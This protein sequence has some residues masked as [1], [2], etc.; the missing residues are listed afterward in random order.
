VKHSKL[1]VTKHKGEL[2]DQIM[3]TKREEVA[4]QMALVP[5]SQVKAFA[6]LAPPPLDFAAALTAKPGVALIAEVKRASPSRGLIARDWDPPLIAET[7][8]RAGAAAISCLTDKRYFQGDLTYLTAI[9]DHL[10]DLG[11]SVPVLRKDFLFHEYQIYESRMAGADAILLIVAALSD[12][13]LKRLFALAAD[14][15]MQS[16]VEVHN[17]AELARAARLPVRL[18]GVNNRDLKTFEVDIETTARLRPLMP[19]DVLLIAESGIRTTDDVAH[20]YEIGCNAM[21]VGETF[22]RLPQGERAAAVREF[23]RAGR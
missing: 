19:A 8:A 4:A 16:L 15:G 10:R 13:E 18:V 2:L 3:A 6:R 21:L 7:Y 23:V 1:E 20:L 17:E 9:K 12:A 22:C 11:V 5:L 14:L